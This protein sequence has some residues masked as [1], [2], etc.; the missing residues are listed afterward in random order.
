[1]KIKH[2]EDVSST[3]M[4]NDVVKGVHGRVMIGRN[5]GADNFCMRVFEID[6]GGHTPKHSH[7]W[8][9]EIFIH[10]GKGAF[11][12]NGAWTDVNPGTT[13]FIPGNELHQIKNTGEDTLAVVCLIPKGVPEL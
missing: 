2:Y 13:V 9:H 4:N 5:D 11:F 6:P 1:M 8:E 7:E 12:N 3:F 10:K